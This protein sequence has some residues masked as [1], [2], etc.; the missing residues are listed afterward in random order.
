MKYI[1]GIHA[2]NLPCELQTSG[3]WHKSALKWKYLTLLESSTSPFGDYGIST[4][5]RNIPEHERKFFVANH[6]R[7][8]LDMLDLGDFSNL[9]GMNRDYIANDSYN[10]QIFCKV[11]LLKNHKNWKNI[12]LFMEKEYLLKWKR[13]KERKDK[14]ESRKA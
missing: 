1:S 8:C 4:E 14:N 13:F 2:L 9:E 12:D 10:E 11:L 5:P 6:I 3:D 7:A